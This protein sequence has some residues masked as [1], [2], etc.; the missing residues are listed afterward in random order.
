MGD[1]GN[2]TAQQMGGN[3][4]NLIV[5]ALEDERYDW[6][7]IDGLSEQTGIPETKV[8]EVLASL[9]QVIVRSSI[10]DDSGR[11]L[12]TTRRHYR[13]THGVGARFLSALS[14]RVA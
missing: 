2:S 9:E 4:R 10:P 5:R 3:L 7:T 8:K 12:Y 6:R 1:N 11:D 14:G 13:Q